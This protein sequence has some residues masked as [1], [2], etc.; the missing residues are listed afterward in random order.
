MNILYLIFLFDGLFPRNFIRLITYYV[1]IYNERI[2][3]QLTD[4]IAKFLKFHIFMGNHRVI[5]N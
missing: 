2:I 3:L 4:S 1:P 5:K